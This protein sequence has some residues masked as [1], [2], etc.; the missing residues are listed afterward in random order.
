MVS[1]A[2]YLFAGVSVI[3]SMSGKPM[4]K[5]FTPAN[6][7]GS[8][9][10]IVLTVI[11]YLALI[12]A[13]NVVMRVYLLRDVW[14]R[15]LASTTVHGIEA[16]A[17]VVCERRT[18]QCAGRGLCRRAGCGRILASDFSSCALAPMDDEPG[19]ASASVQPAGSAVYFDGTSSRRRLVTLAFKDQLELQE[20]PETTTR[21]SYDE[22]RRAD[23]PPGPC[24]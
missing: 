14:A 2:G 22:L 17:N 11:G 10:L 24:A 4:A 23:S 16:A 3:A 19:V 12:L 15:V 18:G 6:L 21:W 8:I 9:S 7:Q 5:L 13:L 20:S 1:F